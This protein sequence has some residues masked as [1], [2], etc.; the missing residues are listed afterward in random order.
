MEFSLNTV[1]FYLILGLMTK[2]ATH[3]SLR[4]R[5]TSAESKKSNGALNIPLNVSLKPKKALQ[6]QDY[7]S[8]LDEVILSSFQQL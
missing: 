5:R 7:I 1:L 4:L 6:N 2:E 3:M 8:C